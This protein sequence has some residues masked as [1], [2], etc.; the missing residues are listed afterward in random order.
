MIVYPAVDLRE[1]RVVQWIGGRPDRERLSLPDPV[2]VARGFQDAGF[3]A[4]HLVDLDAALGYGSNHRQ[5]REV[6]DATSVPVQVGGGIRGR[7]AIDAWL[8]AGASRVI[9]GTRAVS[10]SDW[11]RE[12]SAS[13]PDRILVAAD[14]RDGEVVTHGW[15]RGSGHTVEA[16][17]AAVDDL[18]LAG[19][20]VTDVGR[21]GSLAGIDTALFADLVACTTLP[22]IAAGGIGNIQDLRALATV[23]VAGAVVGTALY[24]GDIDPSAAAQEFRQ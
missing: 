20:L 23:G 15:R 9:I 24:T 22:I 18:A 4:L 13:F 11:L 17:L 6:I 8:A 16:F 14:V 19:L 5:V 12:T 1:G 2:A 3:R 21:E 10:D 7:A